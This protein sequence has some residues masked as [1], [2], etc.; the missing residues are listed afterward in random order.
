MSAEEHP[1]IEM[2]YQRMVNDGRV[3]LYH[4]PE[5]ATDRITGAW[6]EVDETVVVEVYR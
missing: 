6:I 2:E 4:D 1:A 5:D 3:R